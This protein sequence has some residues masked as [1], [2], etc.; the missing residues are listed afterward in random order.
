MTSAHFNDGVEFI[1]T[2]L[3]EG[4]KWLCVQNLTQSALEEISSY[5]Y[6]SVKGKILVHCQVGVSRSATS[7]GISHA[8]TKHDADRGNQEGERKKRH[9]P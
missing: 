6:F 3:E 7:F 4:G 1:H 5:L 2:A 8:K 9:L